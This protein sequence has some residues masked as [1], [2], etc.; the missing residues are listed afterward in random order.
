MKWIE[1]DED[2]VTLRKG[3]KMDNIIYQRS[4]LKPQLSSPEKKQ[5]R[6]KNVR[7][8]FYLTLR[9][10]VYIACVIFL[11]NHLS[12]HNNHLSIDRFK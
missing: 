4:N 3:N 12:H 10:T 6:G 8:I 2:R 9:L 7:E 5:F 1:M 11:A